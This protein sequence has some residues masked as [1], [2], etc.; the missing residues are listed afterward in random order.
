MDHDLLLPHQLDSVFILIR[1]FIQRYGSP[2]VDDTWESTDPA[3]KRTM[4][5]LISST[6]S[7][8]AHWISRTLP[9]GS[10]LSAQS[11]TIVTPTLQN[12]TEVETINVCCKSIM[13]HIQIPDLVALERNAGPYAWSFH[14][15]TL[16]RLYGLISTLQLQRNFEECSLDISWDNLTEEVEIALEELFDGEEKSGLLVL[17]NPQILRNT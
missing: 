2:P 15:R 17:R 1:S 8:C 5:R 6:L 3:V 7:S 13:A 16:T 9:S 11:A 10:E 4:L 14:E 12:E